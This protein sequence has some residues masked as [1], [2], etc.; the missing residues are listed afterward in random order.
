MTNN[1]NT[2]KPIP[3]DFEFQPL[4]TIV[5]TF[6]I[7]WSFFVAFNIW[8]FFQKKSSIYLKPRSK[9][10]IFFSAIGQYL[11]MTSQSF[12]IIIRPENFPNSIDHWFLWLLIPL[13]FLAYPIRSIRFTIL[14]NKNRYSEEQ[15]EQTNQNG[16]LKFFK[17][18]YDHPKLLSDK[19]TLI[20]Y[21]V[22]LFCSFL[23][24][25]YRFIKY[26]INHFGQYGGGTTTTFYSVAGG[27]LLVL[28]ILLAIAIYFTYRTNEALKIFLELV[29]ILIFWI[30][31]A[32]PFAFSGY[33]SV[34]NTNSFVSKDIPS[35]FAIALCISSFLVSFGMPIHL[36]SMKQAKINLGLV[37][38]KSFSNLIED[39]EAFK[40]FNKFLADRMAVETMDCYFAIKKFKETTIAENLLTQF[41]F[42]INRYVDQDSPQ[43]VNISAQLVSEL[44]ALR[45]KMT[46][47]NSNSF[48]ALEDEVTKLLDTDLLPEFKKTP[49]AQEFARARTAIFDGND[50][51]E[52]NN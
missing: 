11:M 6:W 31:L 12:K 22:F 19:Y 33:L 26:P 5:F 28:I 38:L 4:A 18:F 16:T 52:K 21:G 7:Q 37:T 39:H 47:P 49:E 10:L 8:L 17:F 50:Q 27:L 1:G 46:Q 36:A 43:H 40:L 48:K 2:I 42:I 32:I 41:N 45:K 30:F 44:F 35:L 25:F 24:G 23:W 9:W 29:L 15:F 51:P 3:W 13:H 20:Y 34:K 14:I